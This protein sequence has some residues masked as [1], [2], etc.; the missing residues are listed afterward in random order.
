MTTKA[1]VIGYPVSHSLSPR[2]HGFWLK[3][4]GINGTYEA[5]EVKPE[6]L[7]EFIKY[8]M[9]N[10]KYAGVNVTLPHKERAF[11]LVDETSKLAYAQDL[12]AVNTIIVRSGRSIG[13]NTDVEGFIQNIVTAEPDFDFE[14][15]K[16]V[17]LGAGGAA[18]A[19]V[20]A[21]ANLK[22]PEIIIT[23]R[24]KEKAEEIKKLLKEHYEDMLDQKIKIKNWEEKKEALKGANLLVNTT[25]LGMLG[26]EKLDIDLSLLPKDA[27][28]T[29]IVYNP[30][31]T[32]LLKAAKK[33]G[34]KTVDG[35]GML[36][37]QAAP[38]FKAWYCVGENAG[39]QP[40]VTEELRAYVLEGL[41]K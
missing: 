28:V 3:K 29:D 17:V 13:K 21:L 5:I 26:K 30:I 32:D 22:V 12:K 31:E 24:T 35:L 20:F 6:N 7:E 39:I 23:N 15:G 19:V 25:S 40:E 10:E 33:R 34:N 18:R 9:A 16:A 2:I 4:Y 36:L 14:K 1:G 41:N 37:Y 27:L 11:L 38:G 8:D